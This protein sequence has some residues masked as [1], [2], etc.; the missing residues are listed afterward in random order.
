MS[1]TPLQW[2]KLIPLLFILLNSLHI[3]VNSQ[4]LD[5]QRSI[6]L[7]LKQ[8]WIGNQPTLETW[9]A[10]SSPC[11][12]SRIDCA[13]DMVI[14]V[15]LSNLYI[16]K[17]IPATICELQSLTDLDL[18][19]NLIPGEFPTVLYNCS[20][21]QYLR[22]VKNSFVGQLPQD[23]HNLSNLQLLDLADNGFT[24]DIPRAMGQLKDLSILRLNTNAFNGTFPAD[25]GNLS[26]LVELELYE[27]FGNLSSLELLDLSSNDLVGSIPR[28]LVQLKKLRSLSL[29]TNKLSGE[30][31]SSFHPLNWMETIDLSTNN[32]TGQ[33]P[34]TLS[35]LRKLSDLILFDNHLSGV[36]P[37]EL[38]L[39]S[40]LR[41]LD[42]HNN[43]IS[44]QRPKSLCARWTLEDITAFSNNL[45]GKIPKS[46]AE[47]SSLETIQL[48]NNGFSGEVPPG[49]WT[50][51]S[52][53]VL[54]LS[55]N[56]FSGSFPN[57][58]TSSMK[59]LEID[60]NE[61]SGQIPSR[62]ADCRTLYILNA[63]N[64]MISGHIPLELTSLQELSSL[65]LDGNQL[66]GEIPSKNISW[67]TLNSLNLARN[68]LSGSIPPALG[69]LPELKY[70]DLSQNDLS[71]P[72]PPELGQFVR[73]GLLNLS[74]N[75]LSGQI[76]P[77]LDS[78]EYKHSFFNN[79]KLCTSSRIPDFPRCLHSF[80]LL[81]MIPILGAI[82]ILVTIC[83][84]LSVCQKRKAKHRPVTVTWNLIPFQR[85]D[86][87]EAN[88]LSRLTDDTIIG[89][90]GSGK[91]YRI[92]IEQS[93]NVVA[94]K[95]ILSIRK[96][97]SA[98][99]ISEVQVLGRIRHSNIVKLLCCISNEEAKL[100]VYDLRVRGEPK[101]RQVAYMAEIC[102]CY[103]HHD[104][105]PPII[106]RD[107]KSSNILLDSE[108]NAKIADFGLAKM[109]VKKHGEPQTVSTIAGS[110]GY[111]APELATGNKPNYVDDC[112]NLAD[113]AWKHYCNGHPI[114]EALDQEIKEPC[115]LEEMSNVFKLGLKCTSMPPSCRPSMKEV[116]QVLLCVRNFLGDGGQGE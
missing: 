80:K 75:K 104:C 72:I 33:I 56:G 23:I 90:G 30:I 24:G 89:S 49:V 60:N 111:L 108:F 2:P 9:D 14:G 112:L 45:S 68:R 113:W 63:S 87:T 10:I 50:L 78:A 41:R 79:P 98:Q 28:S 22:L 69:S 12:W 59:R 115:I 39:H 66:S 42:V 88:I 37:P 67:I 96:S 102:L 47:C 19:Y 55:S 116:L 29:D 95:K 73:H 48:H 74:S 46:L 7:N 4:S 11:N 114:A 26:K 93:A 64:N 105:S 82:V 70:L 51:T 57:Q 16:S 109:L 36:L 17:E 53:S 13:D 35:L 15:F 20:N 100:L 25:I 52:L 101:P 76:P 18:S 5:V 3:S 92:S 27:S 54:T 86:F 61:F 97:D 103:L 8:Q 6:L 106:H 77:S 81:P 21:L 110:F 44:G 85:L 99:F 62:I 65:S 83:C 107:V 84:T 1:R 38:G 91:V 40:M 58:L 94:V 43:Q 34:T 71:D 32:L 31:P